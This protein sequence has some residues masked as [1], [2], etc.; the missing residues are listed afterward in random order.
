MLRL[1]L[2]SQIFC[3]DYRYY[4]IR[5]ALKTPPKVPA[6]I[7]ITLQKSQGINFILFTVKFE[8]LG[9]IEIIQSCFFMH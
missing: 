5:T 2:V 9:N 3:V 6:K 7:E 4:Q 8:S 1:R